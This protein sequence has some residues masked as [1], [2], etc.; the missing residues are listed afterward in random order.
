MTGSVTRIT[1]PPPNCGSWKLLDVRHDI[2]VASVSTPVSP[3]KLMVAR[4]CNGTWIWEGVQV[5]TP[6]P[7]HADVEAALCDMEYSGERHFLARG[8]R[9]GSCDME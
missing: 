5:A 8:R 6:E 1:P 2:L 7:F 4:H 3:D 9:G